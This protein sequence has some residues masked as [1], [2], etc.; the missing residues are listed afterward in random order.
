MA[1]SGKTAAPLEIPYLEES[2]IPDMG[3]GDKAIAERA[4]SLLTGAGVAQLAGG[5]AGEG[6]LLIAQP[7]DVARFKALKGDATLAEDG[8]LTVA[9][10][11]ITSRKAKLTAGIKSATEDLHPLSTSYQ[12]VPGTS[13]EIT[14]AAP[15]LLKVTA[16]FRLHTIRSSGIEEPEAFG[17]VRIDSEDQS[18]PANLQSNLATPGSATLE[19]TATI[20]QVYLLSLTTASHT[21]KLRA[22]SSKSVSGFS[23]CY[24][25]GTRFLYELIAS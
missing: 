15:S 14:P 22:K 13:L 25:E 3:A 9:D 8:T 7:G 10:G 20:L 12:D 19:T 24:A 6:Q 5:E 11:A 16:V 4:H 2:D 18:P 23:R 21:I 1:V 17:T